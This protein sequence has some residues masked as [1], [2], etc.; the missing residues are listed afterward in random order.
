[1]YIV[2]YGAWTVNNSVLPA[3]IATI[4]FINTNITFNQVEIDTDVIAYESTFNICNSA[5]NFS[6]VEL[7]NSEFYAHNAQVIG[8]FSAYDSIIT[9]GNSELDEILSYGSTNT[10]L[11]NTT[12]NH[13][14]HHATEFKGFTL[15]NNVTVGTMDIDYDSVNFVNVNVT[16]EMSVNNYLQLSN[17]TNVNTTL[18]SMKVYIYDDA[19]LTEAGFQLLPTDSMS[20]IEVPNVTY[21]S[22]QINQI[23][24]YSGAILKISNVTAI[25]YAI[26]ASGS[27][28]VL[29][30]SSLTTGR[31]SISSSTLSIYNSDI[32]VPS[33]YYF[34]I[35]YGT[36][37]IVNST[38]RW[39]NLHEAIMNIIN[40][41]VTHSPMIYDSVVNVVNSSL[42]T[43][44]SS[45][46]TAFNSKLNFTNVV[47]GYNL[48]PQIFSQQNHMLASIYFNNVTIGGTYTEMIYVNGTSNAVFSDTGFSG[49][50]FNITRQAISTTINSKNYHIRVFDNG[51]LK[52][53]NAS[54]S[55]TST[56]DGIYGYGNATIL[57]E[58]TTLNTLIHA[59]DFTSV[60]LNNTQMS[61]YKYMWLYDNSILRNVQGFPSTVYA[62]YSYDN[63]QILLENIT[64]TYMIR[65]YDYAFVNLTNVLF[66]GS[67]SLSVVF[68]GH[69]SGVV[70]SDTLNLSSTVSIADNSD[71]DNIHIEKQKINTFTVSKFA[72]ISVVDSIINEYSSNWALTTTNISE[73]LPMRPTLINTSITTFNNLKR[74]LNNE[75][76]LN[77]S[78]LFSL[79]T[80]FLG[81]AF[82]N[83]NVTTF[84]QNATY[85]VEK[86]TLDGYNTTAFAVYL[87]SG[88][89]SPIP[90]VYALSSEILME[91]GGKQSIMWKLS[92]YN[93][94]RYYIYENGTQVLY[95][96][97]QD[98]TTITWDLSTYSAGIY[99]FTIL[100]N[101][102][103][104]NFNTSTVFVTIVTP[105]APQVISMAQNTTYESG[106]SA[107]LSWT[108][109]DISPSEYKIYVNG[110]KKAI[111]SWTNGTPVTFTLNETNEGIYNVTVSFWDKVGNYNSSSAFVT[112]LL[113]QAPVVT[114]LNSTT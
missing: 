101:N 99:N 11:T 105:E 10:T 21:T 47:F 58:N 79:T 50:Y 83:T 31:I 100:G 91:E 61:T 103:Y 88:S 114:F 76:T 2:F 19:N 93:P 15:L 74:F 102:R 87:L 51:T 108:A 37:T 49:T 95:G 63:S 1:M 54:S 13:L 23:S 42:S 18:L 45:D 113:A 28:L 86:G 33:Q 17:F 14:K 81:T 106:L 35:Y 12:V 80:I 39:F 77:S 96:Y 5:A 9:A 107:T 44:L 94:N 36:T 70:R 25:S 53:F 104:G 90:S 60:V 48:H 27:T 110:T 64:V 55:D 82:S 78:G 52:L 65:A 7:D 41:T 84:A 38:V 29:D 92:D 112:V 8:S 71:S 22:Y 20:F 62:A 111:D 4:G 32:Q 30:N 16:N 68:N 72:N 6:S 3:G 26:Y 73:L 109:T 46:F 66:S 43:S 97:Y 59:Y 69:S 98:M 85:T 40:S 89:V 56:V 34:T 67:S 24:V 75:S 57:L